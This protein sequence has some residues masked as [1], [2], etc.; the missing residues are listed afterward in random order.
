MKKN[1]NKYYK[2]IIYN[3]LINRKIIDMKKLKIINKLSKK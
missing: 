1:N 2:K 3:Y